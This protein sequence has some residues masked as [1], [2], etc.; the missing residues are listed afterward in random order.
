MVVAAPEPRSGS[1]RVVIDQAV[2]ETALLTT[3][4]RHR[5]V[6][7]PRCGYN[8]RNLTQPV[9][10]ECR[11]ALSLKVDVQPLAIRWLLLTVAPGMFC[12]ILLAIFLFM[13]MRHGP[14][15]G[16]PTEAV[17]TILFIAA[18]A[19]GSIALAA[20][21]R[22]FLRLPEPAQVITAIIVWTAHIA[23]FLMITSRM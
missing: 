6:R 5:D 8:L 3:F 2:D 18:S 17:L 22:S 12:A 4:L 23:V 14:P 7:C 20:F 9:C 21:N 16:M 11:E 13:S 15:G 10:P 19:I 1:E